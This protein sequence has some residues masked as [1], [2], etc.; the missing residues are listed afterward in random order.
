MTLLCRNEGES[1][2]GRYR[3]KIDSQDGGA[4]LVA[5]RHAV[6]TQL[7]RWMIT[8]TTRDDQ[9]SGVLG[10]STTKRRMRYQVR[11]NCG[12]DGDSTAPEAVVIHVDTILC[13]ERVQTYFYA[14][15]T[16]R[17]GLGLWKQS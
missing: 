13:L 4:F 16:H 12:L 3:R 7:H 14:E 17:A 5:G 9:R 15:E 11:V 6:M 1:A 10:F 2:K 8:R